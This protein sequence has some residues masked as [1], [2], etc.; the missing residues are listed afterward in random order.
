MIK[1]DFFERLDALKRTVR[2]FFC[3]IAGIEDQVLTCLGGLQKL[4]SEED[5]VEVKI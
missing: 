1:N 4:Y 3:Y 2:H 5:E